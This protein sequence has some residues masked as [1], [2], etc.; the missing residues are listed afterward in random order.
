MSSSFDFELI[1]RRY[2][3]L[4]IA[5]VFVDIT[6]ICHEINTR[7][8]DQFN[9]FNSY[10]ALIINLT[11]LSFI[12][13]FPSFLITM[14]IVKRY[15]LKAIVFGVH[16]YGFIINYLT[17]LPMALVYIY[18][19]FFAFFD[20]TQKYRIEIHCI[21]LIVFQVMAIVDTILDNWK[22]E[23]INIYNF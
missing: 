15:G 10:I 6:L 8:E 23:L 19:K 22:P 18:F 20:W 5:L 16:I 21:E 2:I 9:E 7:I 13:Y 3:F 11:I 4:M 14:L 17:F 1:Y 12:F